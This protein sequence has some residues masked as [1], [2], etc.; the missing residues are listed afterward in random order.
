MHVVY[1]VPD[2]LHPS[3]NAVSAARSWRFVMALTCRRASADMAA[4]RAST[5]LTGAA[6]WSATSA[7]FPAQPAPM[8]RCQKVYTARFDS[9]AHLA[10]MSD[11]PRAGL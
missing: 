8:P 4:Q 10:E 7:L 3:G 2:P 9:N 6:M 11:P 5:S 1:G